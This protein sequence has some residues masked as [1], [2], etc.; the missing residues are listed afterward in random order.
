VTEDDPILGKKPKDAHDLDLDFGSLLVGN[1][2]EFVVGLCSSPP[3]PCQ[4]DVVD[5]GFF[6]WNHAV[7]RLDGR[8]A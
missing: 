2:F 3:D 1:L 4:S 5:G 7:S 8:L 6:S